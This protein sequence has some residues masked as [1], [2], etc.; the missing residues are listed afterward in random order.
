MADDFSFP[1]DFAPD[2]VCLWEACPYCGLLLLHPAAPCDSA[3]AD[4][5]P[6]ALEFLALDCSGLPRGAF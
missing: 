1:L 6:T 5:C 4:T 2:D 3:P